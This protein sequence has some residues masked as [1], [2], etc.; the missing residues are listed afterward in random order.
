MRKK[1][2]V[3]IFSL[4]AFSTTAQ[5]TPDSLSRK[6]DSYIYNNPQEHVFL[7]S[8]KNLALVGENL[9]ISIW[10]YDTYLN[11]MSKLSNLVYLQLISCTKNEVILEQKVEVVNG[12]AMIDFKIPD[13]PEGEYFIRGFSKLT[14][15]DLSKNYY[16]PLFIVSKGIATTNLD[17]PVSSKYFV[18]SENKTILNLTPTRFTFKWNSRLSSKLVENINIE[19]EKGEI[20]TSFK[21]DSLGIGT[22]F[23]KPEIGKNYYYSTNGAREKLDFGKVEE[24]GLY[25]SSSQNLKHHTIALQGTKRF[26]KENGPFTIM[27]I[28]DFEPLFFFESDLKHSSFIAKIEKEKLPN[29]VTDIMVFS[30]TGLFLSGKSFY[31]QKT[32]PLHIDIL[33]D[34]VWKERETSKIELSHEPSSESIGSSILIVNGLNQYKASLS[35]M[36]YFGLGLYLSNHEAL[37]QKPISNLTVQQIESLLLLYSDSESRWEKII[38]AHA[39]KLN[40]IPERNLTIEGK[41]IFH[42][43]TSNNTKYKVS[44]FLSRET[45]FY[46]AFVTKD[47]P[48]FNVPIFPFYGT[49]NLIILVHEED[50]SIANASVRLNKFDDDI[51]LPAFPSIYS[52]ETISEYK[53]EA[54]IRSEITKVYELARSNNN[55][56][57]LEDTGIKYNGPVDLEINIDE[58]IVFG[59]MAEIFHEIISGAVYRSQ[60]NAPYLRIYSPELFRNFENAPL[61]IVDG[62]PGFTADEIINL[63]PNEVS[64]IRLINTSINLVNF[65]NAGQNGVLMVD[66]YQKKIKPKSSNTVSYR[67]EGLSQTLQIKK[68]SLPSK[69]DKKFNHPYFE[70]VLLFTKSENRL[71][72]IEEVEIQCSDIEGFYSIEIEGIDQEGLPYNSCKIVRVQ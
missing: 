45:L 34:S 62:I 55:L 32:S 30:K 63:K 52:P 64:K 1:I 66:T 53:Q 54:L 38:D 39:Q 29:G 7:K 19:N 10:L 3:S 25:L 59:S 22:F 16:L 33:T 61:L 17:N 51:K 65:G 14:I 70:N 43:T 71:L 42:D 68:F 47:Q 11:Q 48:Q 50:N 26:I 69:V 20:I 56:E 44:F 24:E 36:D 46:E 5:N 37:Y 18:K 57:V 31:N 6:I 40:R 8:D 9:S 27:L 2:L 23:M 72:G 12:L 41:V 4:I 35:L 28:H 13:V 58:Y 49:E 15:K 60:N 21:T 67:F